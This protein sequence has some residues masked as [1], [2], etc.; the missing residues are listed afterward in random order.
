MSTVKRFGLLLCLALIP[1]G[2]GLCEVGQP[3]IS[4]QAPGTNAGTAA[5]QT[6]PGQKPGTRKAAAPRRAGELAPDP[7]VVENS[8]YSERFFH[9]QYAIP[10][11]WTVRTDEMRKQLPPSADAV[12][13]LSTSAHP[14]PQGTEVNPSITISAESAA[15]YK[16]GVDPESYLGAIRDYA[17]TRGFKVLNEPAEIE[18]GGVTFVRSDFVREAADGNT[19]QA[20]LVA[21]R[22]G[23][24]LSVTAISGDEEQLTPLLNRLRIVAPPAL[25]P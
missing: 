19:Y 17:A 12:L 16:E 13:L 24:L 6:S 14:Q 21:L 3:T 25:K 1:S 4:S 9:L 18:L 20:S 8:I 15:Q 2:A 22:K 7:G 5:A 23:Y 11:G 10:Q